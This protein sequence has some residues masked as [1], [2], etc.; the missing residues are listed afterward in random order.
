MSQLQRWPVL[1]QGPNSLWPH[2]TVRSLQFLLRARGA[3]I[4]VD[5]IFGP[6]TD[7]AV[8]AFQRSHHLLV[9]GIVGSQ[10]WSSLIITVRQGSRGDAVRAVQD[11]INF[12]DLKG[13]GTLV[14]DGIF[15]PKTR[16]EVIWF[17]EQLALDIK[18]FAVDGIV[19]PQ[20]WPS[21]VN[22]ANSG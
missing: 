20:T 4:T 5:G 14:V 10:T 9:D 16:Q 18:P 12:R 19:G 6:R 3:S 11:Q 15:G 2:A 1:R 22:E 8:V 13:N 7:A 17:Q 21:L